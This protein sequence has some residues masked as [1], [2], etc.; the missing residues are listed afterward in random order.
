MSLFWL[1]GYNF[2]NVMVMVMVLVDVVTKEILLGRVRAMAWEQCSLGLLRVQA[3]SC[4]ITWI[5]DIFLFSP[6][7]VFSPFSAS[8]PSLPTFLRAFHCVH[9]RD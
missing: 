7:F 6:L 2:K 4:N 5:E 8:S 3:W 1:G 9:L